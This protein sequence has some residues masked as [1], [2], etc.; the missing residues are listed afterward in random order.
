[1]TKGEFMDSHYIISVKIV[2][3]KSLHPNW[4][5]NMQIIQ[6]DVG[7]YIDNIEGKQF[8]YFQDA[9][10]GFNWSTYVGQQVRGLKI[11]NDHGYQWLNKR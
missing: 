3:G 9:E 8:G 11:Y 2:Q 5:S 4:K 1:M 10:P 7:L 6:T